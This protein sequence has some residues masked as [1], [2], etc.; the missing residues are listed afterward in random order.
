M[1]RAIGY[2]RRMVVTNFALESAFVAVLG[3]G[4]GTFLGIIVGYQLW[5]SGFRDMEFD[6]I[7]AWGPILLV[8]GLAFVATLLSVYPAARGASKVSPAEVLRFE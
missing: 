7:I 5:E 4:I 6:F 3:I 1:M 8:G 2:T